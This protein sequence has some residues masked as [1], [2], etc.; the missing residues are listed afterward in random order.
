MRKFFG[1]GKSDKDKKAET[2]AA[3]H[4]QKTVEESTKSMEAYTK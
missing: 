2:A 3:L 4:A 1:L